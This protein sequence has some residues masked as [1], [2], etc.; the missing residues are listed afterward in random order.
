MNQLV[1]T[2]Q[3]GSLQIF[4]EALIFMNFACLGC[5]NVVNSTGIYCQ[6]S[7]VSK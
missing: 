1:R 6:R 3:V 5:V 7:A 2:V 4:S